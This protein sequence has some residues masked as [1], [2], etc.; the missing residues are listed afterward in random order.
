MFT[1]FGCEK[2]R[3]FYNLIDNENSENI[4]LVGGCKQIFV[5]TMYKGNQ[6]MKSKLAQSYIF[7]F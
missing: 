4:E 3:D 6:K 7:D 2:K 1:C 5:E